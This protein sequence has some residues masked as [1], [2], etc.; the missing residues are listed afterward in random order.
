M[1]EHFERQSDEQQAAIA[2]QDEPARALCRRRPA[3]ENE[4]ERWLD[5]SRPGLD[6]AAQ[7]LGVAASER[8]GRGVLG[9][10]DRQLVA[11][12]VLTER[13]SLITHIHAIGDPR[14]L[15][16]VTS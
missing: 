13:D 12:L 4:I 14:K 6:G 11:I 1:L 7:Q 3:L 2:R 8:A 16:F 10:R 9:F 15:A 5:T